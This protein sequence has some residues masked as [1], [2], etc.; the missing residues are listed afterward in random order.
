MTLAEAKVGTTV[1]IAAF[2][3]ALQEAEAI[4]LGL[5]PGAELTVVQ[6]LGRGP[7]VVQQGV[8]QIA[9]GYTLA[10]RILLA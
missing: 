7:V 6:K 5:V 9:V 1:R 10:Q 8:T 2:K 3:G 4:R